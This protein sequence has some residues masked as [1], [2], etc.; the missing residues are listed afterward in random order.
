MYLE[1]NTIIFNCRIPV[2]FWELMTGEKADWQNP[3]KSVQSY[4]IARA[5]NQEMTVIPKELESRYQQCVEMTADLLEVLQNVDA[6]RVQLLTR[7]REL[8]FVVPSLGNQLD[9]LQASISS[10]ITRAIE[11]KEAGE[12]EAFSQQSR[13][14][15]KLIAMAGVYYNLEDQLTHQ[16]KRIEKK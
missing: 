5:F 13:N 4:I 12:L 11:S 2:V 9:S 8:G 3:G 16:E 15:D 14:R 10:M 7:Y 1:T 6:K